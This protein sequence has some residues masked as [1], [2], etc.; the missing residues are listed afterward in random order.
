MEAEVSCPNLS[1]ELEDP[2]FLRVLFHDPADENPLSRAPQLFVNG[3]RDGPLE[4]TRYPMTTHA[5]G[6]V[7]CMYIREDLF[8]D[9]L[10]DSK[11]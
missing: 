1:A 5:L 2:P 4:L 7:C 6:P 8:F 10:F 3:L 9:H 11:L